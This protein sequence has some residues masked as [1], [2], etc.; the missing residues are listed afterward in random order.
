MR[1]ELEIAGIR[2]GCGQKVQTYVRV[3]DTDLC[4]P[5]T[6]INGKEDGKIILASAGIHGCEYPG[7]MA[8]MELGREIDPEHVSGA[9]IL[10]HE[11]NMSSFLKRQPYV[12]AADEERKNLN[13]IFPTDGSGT[14]AD[15][16][17]CFLSEE[18][19][20][21]ID[22]HVDLHSGD[23][24]EEL[25]GCVIVANTPDE[26]QKASLIE[27]AKHTRFHLRMNSGGRREFYNSS[28]IH[29]GKPALLF[30]R[31]HS[32]YCRRADVDDDKADLLSVMSC[33]GILPGEPE[34]N[35]DQ[36]F[37]WRHEWTQAQEGDNGILLPFVKLGDEIQEGQKLF[38]IR[39]MFGELIRTVHAKHDG[40]VF[41]ISH[42][43]SVTEGDDL[44]AYGQ[45]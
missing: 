4:F 34:E 32:G 36:V 33:L 18:F 12:M 29:Y 41:I 31:G 15:R 17:C 24:V 22:F 13:R 44:I 21:G 30:E 11:V 6:F 42:T 26:E 9:I 8:V 2:V 16:L 3:P 35:P 38:E 40:H 39:D 37:F 23:M 1:K 5:C 45:V 25:E 27:I 28:A 43:L 7:V 14:L 19:I 10:I 20:P